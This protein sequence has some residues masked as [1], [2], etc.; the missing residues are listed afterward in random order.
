V[1][2]KDQ[3]G[4]AERSERRSRERQMKEV[5]N[6]P[7]VIDEGIILSGDYLKITIY[8]RFVRT[9]AKYM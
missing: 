1:R 3:R 4:E 7:Q 9:R 2:Q 5:E 6:L 8:S